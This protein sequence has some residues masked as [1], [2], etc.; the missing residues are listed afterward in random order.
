MA[1]V[2]VPDLHGCPHFL[3]WVQR[4]FP[5]R[6]LIVLGDLINRGPDSRRVLQLALYLAAE[7]RATLLWGNHEDWVYGQSSRLKP[8]AQERWFRHHAHDLFKSYHSDA[9]ALSADLRQFASLAE[10]YVVE[11]AMLCAHAARPSLGTGPDDLLDMGYM[12]DR[13]ASGLHPLP[14]HF[15]PDLR[16]S[17]HGHTPV[18]RPVVDLDGEGVVY[19]DLG[20][21]RTGRFCVWDAETEAVVMYP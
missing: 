20:T 17:V 13:P 1:S 3:E 11:G 9:R 16:Y 21:V 19:I 10:P 5:E 15:F 12:W 8:A 2:V 4:R 7:G 18:K 14:M 6:H